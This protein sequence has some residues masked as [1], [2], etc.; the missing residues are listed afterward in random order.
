M[1]SQVPFVH[2]NV[3]TEYSLVDG[4]A[5][6]KE[7]A[8][9]VRD[10]HMPAVAMTDVSNMYAAV[11]FYRACKEASVKPLLGT[12]ITVCGDV[13]DRAKGQMI[14]LCRNNNG[15]QHLGRLLTETYV[16]PRSSHGIT[17]KRSELFAAADDLIVVSGGIDSD[18]AGLLRAGHP[19][20][21]LELLM[22]Y[23]SAF[24]DRYYLE[25]SR[26]GR[27]GEGE[28]EAGALN[29]AEQT[30][31]P[32][33]ASNVVR[34]L[35]ADDFE[36]HEIRV[37]IHE[38][39]VI[40][41]PRRP[42]RFTDQ[43]YLRDGAE[44]TE[45]FSDLPSALENSIQIARRCNVFLD[46]ESTHMPQFPLP[47]GRSAEEE[48]L[49]QARV[50][51][52][53]FQQT[54]PNLDSLVYRERLEAEVDTIN[55]MGFAGYFLIVADF[56]R[57]AI[58]NGVP[59]GPGR[60]SGAGSLVAFALGITRLDPI[61]YGL[62]FERFLNPERVSLPDFDIDFCMVGRDR[63][64]DY[65]SDKY[66]A[67]KVAQII[68]YN[69]LAARAVVRDV[70]RVMGMP[71]GFCD[72]LAKLIPFEVGMT[73]ERA[74]EQ[75]DELRRRFR[76]EAEVSQLINNARRLEGL[77]RNAG[78]HAG[79]LVIAPR[80]IS[81]FSP[82]YWEPGMT[83][84]V[85]Q[86]D[87]DDLEAIGLVK[88]DFLGLRTLTIIDWAL[89]RVNDR[90]AR[91]GEDPIVLDSLELDDPKVYRLICTGRT[92]ALFQLES[93]GM[94]E[95]IQRLKPDHFEELV[96]LVALFRPG[97]LQSGMVDDFINRKHGREPV[98]Y[99][100]KALE[101]VLEP[102]YGVI[103]YQEQVMQIAQLLAGYSLGAADLLRRAMGKKKVEEMEKQRQGFIDGATARGV[104]GA[105]ARHIFDLIEKFA[106][107]GF[108]KS[109]S[110][111]YALLSYHTGWLKC[112]YPAEFLS[113]ALS[114]D[115]E[116]TDRI[117]ILVNEAKALC[118]KLNPPDINRGGLRFEVAGHDTII[119]GLGAI[120]GVGEKALEDILSE[121]SSDGPFP[122]FFALCR[123]INSQ[124]VNRKTLEALICA[125]ALDSFGQHRAE[126]LGHLD[127]AMNAA[128]Q[129]EA[130]LS[131]GQDDMFG[132]GAVNAVVESALDVRPWSERK[133]LEMERLS[134]GL[135][136][137]GHPVD[138]H[139]AELT[140][141]TSGPIGKI[142]AQPERMII[143]AGLITGLR[144]F[145]NRRGETMAFFQLDDPTGRAD[146]SVFGEL[147]SKVRATLG[148]QGVVIVRGICGTDDR[149][150]LLAVK[151]DRVL[152]LEDSRAILLRRIA[153]HLSWSGKGPAP[154]EELQR[155]LISH[156]PGTTEVVVHYLNS[157]G[158]EVCMTLGS[159]WHVFPRSDL[160]DSLR[161]LVGEE[162]VKLVFDP[163]AS[164]QDVTD[165]SLIA[166]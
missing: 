122:D 160:L 32:L 10:A 103:L 56:I 146:V 19:E 64:I 141:M 21:A 82:L 145:Q 52:K 138:H 101:E 34:F 38:G 142:K 161:E 14:L 84:P 140:E 125:G 97:P 44:M 99:V 11:K 115:M 106:G 85:T 165:S 139:R 81:E 16:R 126:L 29:L 73:L 113:A 162:G 149:S 143:L 9:S 57:W 157:S 43:Q 123:R 144:T 77:P 35:R 67:E 120:K 119:Y 128:S 45:L 108:N 3:H 164:L 12:E 75:D 133:T 4:I 107:Y 130:N 166:A 90:R 89:D 22:Q 104:E 15:L 116:H 17:V 69:S 31:T 98:L 41:D 37:C 152:A 46:F 72:S 154:L 40:D 147:Y 76:E 20:Q 39:R 86:F 88:F 70:G 95:L 92:T 135:Y 60:G 51:L 1:N 158:D 159:E 94:Q 105:I 63:V 74:L 102:T 114:A 28:Y 83:Q 66:G 26:T 127:A 153:I 8:A 36:A 93:R 121:R 150:G 54:K 124:K 59:V 87:K 151:A 80:A 13:D 136:L 58:S 61:R 91:S 71:Y 79:G 24:G 110:A 100:H 50:G 129:H 48:L 25:I 2:L 156:Q 65:V 5:R 42:R 68:T 118:L 33:V 137:T 53:A 96:A 18:V 109:H 131:S 47:G 111:A 155:L 62:L 30:G 27:P 117:V 163:I 7:L 49:A 55:G 23:R 134:L 6:V 78:K 148:S 132:L 112:H